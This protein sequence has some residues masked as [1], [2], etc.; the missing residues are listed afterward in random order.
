MNSRWDEDGN[1]IV[2]RDAIYVGIATDTARGLLVPVIHHAE[3]LDLATTAAEGERLVGLARDGK[4]DA[5][6][7]TGGTITVTNVGAAGPVATG[8]PPLDP[9]ADRL[10]ALGARTPPRTSL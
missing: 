5:A 8:P 3:A 9:P 6:A 7:L 4:L 2:V 1:A 10:V